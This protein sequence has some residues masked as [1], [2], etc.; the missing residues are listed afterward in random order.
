MTL[1]VANQTPAID[2]A[3]RPF[4]GA[5][6]RR[7]LVRHLVGIVALIIAAALVQFPTPKRVAL[8]LDIVFGLAVLAV[9]RQE[10]RRWGIRGLGSPLTLTAVSWF[11][12]FGVSGLGGF[13]DAE[14]DPRLGFDP[15]NLVTALVVCMLSL[16]LVFVGYR[17][18]TRRVPPPSALEA[19]GPIAV[20]R[21]A[22]YL[23]LLVGWAA[24][25][26]LL[27]AGQFGFLSGGAT[28]TGPVNR[29]VQSAA[30]GLTV[31]LVVLVIAAWSPAGMRGMTRG[32]ARWLLIANLIPLALA[33]LASG[34][35][36]QLFTEVV[37]LAAAYVMVRGRVPWRAI[38]A[39]A[40]YLM[41]IYSGTQDYRTDILQGN[42]S[43]AER[44]GAVDS[45]SNAV[46]SVTKGWANDPP[47]E[48]A[49]L[50]WDHLTG[51]YSEMLTNLAIIL[52]R[53]PTEVPFLGNRRLITGPVFFLPTSLLGDPAFN[54]NRYVNV[55]YR[56]STATSASP[57]TQPGDFFL[58]GGW[59]A[60][61]V[62]EL[63]VGMFIGGLWRLVVLRRRSLTGVVVYAAVSG[64]FVTAGI[65]W[66]TL[67]RGLLQTVGVAWITMALIRSRKPAEALA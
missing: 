17:L 7:R 67:S 61:V 49:Q 19:T 40:V 31:G 11:F 60:L 47:F 38:A 1:Q 46:T 29:L 10:R 30:A 58:S 25:L 20:K 44:A 3:V 28:S 36:G 2:H 52:H 41:V 16:A 63:V 15:W 4:D 50:V 26:Y 34:L 23:V 57:P 64:V 51:T 32:A 66:G 18:A 14:G 59:P 45:V 22:L 9:V 35:K 39:I 33:S 65:D 43:A 6:G 27:E 8:S 54:I 56:N 48:K 24:R 5:G 62:G 53:T 12:F 21:W 13:V 42:L 55:V 37:P